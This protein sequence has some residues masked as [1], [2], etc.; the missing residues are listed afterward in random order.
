MINKENKVENQLREKLYKIKNDGNFVT[1]VLNLAKDNDTKSMLL[2]YLEEEPNASE[3]NILLLTMLIR[4]EK[5]SRET[6]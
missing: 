5:R 3:R 1:G 6:L 2:E 4:K